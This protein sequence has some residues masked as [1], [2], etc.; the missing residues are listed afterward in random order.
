LQA[1]F[2]D[3][4]RIYQD[5]RR[6]DPLIYYLPAGDWSRSIGLEILP[7]YEERKSKSVTLRFFE[8]HLARLR[9]M[10][11]SE[12][13]LIIQRYAHSLSKSFKHWKDLTIEFPDWLVGRIGEGAILQPFINAGWQLHSKDMKSF[14]LKR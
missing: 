9:S 10:T 1:D 13:T 5:P 14:Q 6:E 8:D 3:K 7:L 12:L 4:D 11:D 2:S